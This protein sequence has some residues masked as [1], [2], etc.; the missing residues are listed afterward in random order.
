MEIMADEL[1]KAKEEAKRAQNDME[2]LLDVVQ[3]SQE[4]QNTKEKQIRELQE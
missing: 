4:E 3:V 2:R 1:T